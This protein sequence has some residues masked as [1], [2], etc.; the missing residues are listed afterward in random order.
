MVRVLRM[1]ATATAVKSMFSGIQL[2]E[3]SGL[4]GIY[5]PNSPVPPFSASGGPSFPIYAQLT[6]GKTR[7]GE[8]LNR[9]GWGV[10]D[11]KE[12]SIGK[13]FWFLVSDQ[14]TPPGPQPTALPG[15]SP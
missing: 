1:V 2:W 5:N 14:D 3:L 13:S 4:F 11:R 7:A 10:G 8:G 6:E 15:Q 9:T 12:G